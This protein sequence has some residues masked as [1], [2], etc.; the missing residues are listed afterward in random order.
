MTNDEAHVWTM[1]QVDGAWFHFDPTFEQSENEGAGLLYFG[2]DDSRRIDTG[3]LLPIG[4]GVDSWFIHN[5][6]ECSDDRLAVFAGA[7]HWEL[8]STAHLLRLY[9]VEGEAPVVFDTE[10]LVVCP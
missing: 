3:V 10:K 5:A 2:M 9:Y 8:D 1:V 4:S 6:P 7:T